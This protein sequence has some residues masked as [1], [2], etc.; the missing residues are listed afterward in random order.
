MHP[1]DDDDDGDDDVNQYR[2]K[3]VGEGTHEEQSLFLSPS[4]Y[5]KGIE[6]SSMAGGKSSLGLS[7]P[8]LL[9]IVSIRQS[10]TPLPSYHEWII[11]YLF[12]PL[13]FS[14]EIYIAASRWRTSSRPRVPLS[15]G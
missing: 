14:T 9:L 2:W 1:V 11:S 12:R 6:I 10:P 5:E 7:W 15:S 13:C 8:V 4:E 3:R